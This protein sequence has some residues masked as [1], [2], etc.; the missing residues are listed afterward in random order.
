MAVPAPLV[1]HAAAINLHE[2]HTALDE[3][4]GDEALLGEVR[5]ARIIQAVERLSR[6]R[7]LF[8]VETF[9][10]RHLHAVGQFE[11]LDAGGQLGIVGRMF[12]VPL[13]ELFQQVEL[14][15]L[16]AV[17]DAWC[18]VQVVD[19]RSRR[20][21]HRPLINAGQETRTPIRGVAFRQAAA[22]RVV[23]RDKAGETFILAS[24]AV[25]HP[26]AHAG[27]THSRHARV[28]HEQGGRMIVGRRPAGVDERHLVD[29]LGEVRENLR[30]PFAA[31]AVLREPEGG[32]HHRADL[33]GEK[34]RALIEALEFLTVALGQLRLIVPGIDLARSAVE[35][36][37]NDRA[38]RG[39]H[40]TGPRC[41]RV[42][43]LRRA[44]DWPD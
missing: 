16:L 26:R 28:D 6:P 11:A 43:G 9:G 18:P 42:L 38:S 24:Q 20:L 17:A 37:P 3:P 25:G 34:A 13:V 10:G 23:H 31:F 2:P 36:Q 32:L 30:A 33:I 39:I 5:A 44:R 41:E 29:V 7:F 27:E 14:R 15:S 12:Q 19:G 4:S 1:F 8:Q 21:Q 35:K 22:Q 40:V